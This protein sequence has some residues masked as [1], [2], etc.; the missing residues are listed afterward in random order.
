[1]SRRPDLIEALAEAARAINTPRTLAEALDAIVTTAQRSLPEIDHVGISAAYP[2]GRI[3]TLAGTGPVVWELDQLQYG[4]GEGPCDFAIKAVPLVVLE[5]AHIDPRWPNYLPEAVRRGLRSQLALR[6]YT[7][8]KTLGG[9][10]MYSLSS[11]TISADTV[12]TAEL[13]AVHAALALGRIRQVDDL[14][15]A[16][17]TRTTIGMAVGIVMQR[18]GLSSD[19][20]FAFLT[21][22]SSTSNVKLREVARAVV[23]EAEKANHGGGPRGRPVEWCAGS[24]PRC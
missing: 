10:N 9:L 24:S 4:L 20:A 8:E 3:K 19:Q 22:A 2:R 7:E 1:M 17:T 15:A 18:Y 12:Q 21:R 23:D 16:L 11:D 5:H 13:F 6:L 14:N